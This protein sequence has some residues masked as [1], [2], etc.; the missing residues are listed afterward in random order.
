MRSDRIN[1]CREDSEESHESDDENGY[2]T[3]KSFFLSKCGFHVVGVIEEQSEL[4][5]NEQ[6]L[7][8]FQKSTSNLANVRLNDLPVIF[9]KFVP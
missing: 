8:S 5:D 9:R 7:R 2:D 6:D 4:G 1:H 3:Q